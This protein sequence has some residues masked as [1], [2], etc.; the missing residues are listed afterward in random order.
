MYN[1]DSVEL[2]REIDFGRGTKA[3]YALISKPILAWKRG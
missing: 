1:K 2:R 3:K